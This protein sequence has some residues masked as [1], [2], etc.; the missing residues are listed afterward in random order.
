[1]RCWGYCVSA[2]RTAG[3][4]EAR[5][6]SGNRLNGGQGFVACAVVEDRR[7]RAVMLASDA[8]DLQDSSE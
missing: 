1:M 4:R 7:A 3:Y 5:R 6:S 8:G 2:R